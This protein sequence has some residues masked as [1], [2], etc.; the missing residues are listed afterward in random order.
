MKLKISTILSIMLVALF[1]GCDDFLERVPEGNYSEGSVWKTEADLEYALNGLYRQLPH[2]GDNVSG[3]PNGSEIIYQ[4]FTDD[5]WDRGSSG[6]IRFANIDFSSSSSVISNE[7]DRYSKIRDCNEFIKRA[8]QAEINEDLKA[9]FIAEAR[10]LRAMYYARL[11]FLFGDVPLI[12]EPTDPDYFPRKTKRET[13]F[14]FVRNEFDEIAQ[15]LP[16]EYKGNNIGR[17]TSGAA[18]AFKARH[19]L[20]AIDWYTDLPALYKEAREACETVY[21]SSVYDLDPG[22]EGFRKLFTSESEHGNT[23]EAIL[24]S[25]FDPETRTH[26][27]NRCMLPKAAFGGTNKN[28]SYIGVTNA[29]VEAFQMNNGKD[30]HDVTSGYDPA[31]PWN[32]R[33]PRLDITILRAGEVIPKKGGDGATS[34]YT[35]DPHPLIKPAGGVTTDDV[36]KATN[37]TGYNVWKYIEFDVVSSVDCHVDYKVMRFAEVILM[38]AESILGETGNIGSAM[39]L[40]NE[41]RDRVGMP[42]VETSYG[43]VSSVEKALEIILNERRFELAT[44]GPQRFYDIRRHRLGEEVFADQNVY[45]IPLGPNRKPNKNVLE[46]D[47]DN[48]VKN[49]CGQKKF[50]AET[51]YLWPVPQTAIDRNPSLLEDPE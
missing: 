4:I 33:D 15:I 11:N 40:V 23:M 22:V 6:A 1:W 47:L 25:N 8:P 30:V 34:T 50:N 39:Q 46:G 18:L 32:N 48:G 49:L 45:G 9:R 43:S 13:V 24:T 51:Y 10:F 21:T 26:T 7:W 41:V 2:P 29:L 28:S 42:N 19:L 27:Y 17:I 44:E 38:Y 37:P 12:K 16:N 20:N 3:F 5:G 14:E 31:N 36:T 35:F